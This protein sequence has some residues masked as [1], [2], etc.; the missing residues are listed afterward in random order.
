VRYPRTR[1]DFALQSG[2]L[3]AL[4]LLAHPHRA[5]LAQEVYK[6]TDAQG[7]VVYS[8]RANT[9]TAKKSEVHVTQPD[10]TEVARIAK[11]QEIL[12][13]Q[14]AQRKQQQAVEDKKKAQ[15]DREKQTR[16]DTAR[17]H[18]F[19]MKD[20]RRIFHLDADGNRVYDTDPEA[21]ARRADAKQAMTAA[22][23]T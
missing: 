7:H 15:S 3:V 17:N 4:L 11:E 10:P 20:A 6:S 12:N 14:D 2:T 5:L 23:G 19:S 21:D 1:S 9:S 13:A 22:C 16:C 18:Y 8:D